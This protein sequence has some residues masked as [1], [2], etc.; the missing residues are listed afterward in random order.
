M[1]EQQDDLP[2]AI[3]NLPCK[4]P[5]VEPSNGKHDAIWVGGYKMGHRDARHAAAE[6]VSASSAQKEPGETGMDERKTDG[7][8]GLDDAK[9]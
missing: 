8:K 4:V 5:T 6:L 7:V 1:N 9:A 3:M 2:R